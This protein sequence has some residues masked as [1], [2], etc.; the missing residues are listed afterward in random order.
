[1]A[2]IFLIEAGFRFI[3]H[4]KI[5]SPL[6]TLGTLRCLESILLIIIVWRLEKNTAAIGLARTNIMSGF[7][8]G[9]IWSA[10]FGFIAAGIFIVLLAA[11]VDPLKY[12][13]SLRPSS[14]RHGLVL[15]LVG[16]FIGPIAEEIFFR[17]IIFGFFRKWGATTAIVISTL[18]FVFTHRIGGS[19]P[20]TQVVGG[21]VFAIAYEREKNLMVPITI[22]CLGNLAI[23]SLPILLWR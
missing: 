9:L 5:A 21:V 3:A 2:A 23:F 18:I 14:W 12:F 22:H 11:G 17:G 8:T 10:Y 4:G 1:M 16:G 20:I 6:P 19:I 15:L 7:I 13:Q